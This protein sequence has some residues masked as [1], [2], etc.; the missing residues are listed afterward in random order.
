MPPRDPEECPAL[1]EAPPADDVPNGTW[2]EL[3]DPW[4]VLF[5]DPG[6]DDWREVTAMASWRNRHGKPVVQVEW[7]DGATTWG[8][9]Y[10]TDPERIRP[11]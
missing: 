8:G 10:I 2:R 5:G 11:G 3:G 9:A 6:G 4:K 7:R 1:R